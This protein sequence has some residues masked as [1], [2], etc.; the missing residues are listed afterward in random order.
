M[1]AKEAQSDLPFDPFDLR[2]TKVEYRRNPRARQY[3]LRI[4]NERAVR[5]TIP[6]GG[7][8]RE[9][10]KF[11][12]RRRDWVEGQL[13]RARRLEPG[14]RA[15]RAGSK[16]DYRGE[17]VVLRVECG[18]PDCRI[19]LGDDLFRVGQS[20]LDDLR[21]V[22]LPQLM[23]KA[24]DVLGSRLLQLAQRHGC[25]VKRVTIRAQRTRWGSCSSRGTISL[26]WRLLQAP[27]WVADY[28]MIHELMHLREMNHSGR[29]WKEVARACPGYEKAERWLKKEGRRVLDQ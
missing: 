16:I 19:R 2:G 5:I 10:E 25:R 4:E 9:A 23:H 3:I 8:R 24:R 11:L 12:L 26:N 29:F 28:I 14:P 17:R 6:R 27:P 22:L 15:W 1:K 18:A 20:D 21:Q 13:E 7:S